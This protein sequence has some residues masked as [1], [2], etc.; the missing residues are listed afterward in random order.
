MAVVIDI[1]PPGSTCQRV[2]R[3]EPCRPSSRSK[4][5][6]WIARVTR[7]P[8]LVRITHLLN[9]LFLSLLAR[10]GL[11]ILSAHPELY[12]NRHCRPGSEWLRFTNKRILDDGLWASHDEEAFSSLVALPGHKHLGLGRHWHFA[13]VLGWV[14]TGVAYVVLLF[15]TGEWRRLVPTSWEVIPDAWDALMAYLQ[16]RLPEATAYNGLQQLSYAGVVFGLSP[17]LI[18]TGAAMSPAIDARFPR[19]PKLLGGVQWARSLHFLGLVAVAAF[20]LVHTLMVVIHGLPEGLSRV[21]VGEGAIAIVVSIAALAVIVLLHVAGTAASLRSPRAVQCLLGAIVDP[22][23]GTL[24]RRMSSR[25]DHDPADVSTFFR[26][27]GRPPESAEYAALARDGFAGWRLRASGEVE[28]PLCL[29]LDELR[30]MP[31]ETTPPFIT[32][33]RGGPMSAAGP[34]CRSAICSNAVGRSRRRGTP[35][36][37]RSMTRQ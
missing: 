5:E 8:G 15:G 33:S 3:H 31:R 21:L 2:P 12:W 1:W 35:F 16:F 11:E 30:A 28:E 10:S 18:T 7:F 20:T 6:G 26:V 14:L 24:S 17:F 13:S 37:G 4:L 22:L 23:Q 29:S 32:A 36:S 19:F 9:I 25:Q 34:A 27:N